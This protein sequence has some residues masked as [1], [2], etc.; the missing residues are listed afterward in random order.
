V[1]RSG[2]ELIVF[3]RESGLEEHRGAPSGA[4]DAVDAAA[5]ALTVKTLMRLPPPETVNATP[6]VEGGAE[7]RLQAGLATRIA[8]G[9]ET[10]FSGRFLGSASL[11]P[12]ARIG[13]RFGV[14]IEIGTASD[15]GQFGFRGTWTDWSVVGLA[16]WSFAT[17]PRWELEPY[18]G[19][20]VARSAVTGIVMQD[21]F[22]DTA[23]LG[24]ACAGVWVRR[25]LAMWTLGAGVGAEL[26]PGTPTYTRTGGSG[27][28]IFDVPAFG[29]EIG[30][31]ASADFG[32]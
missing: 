32:R 24:I 31:V 16:S 13:L 2:A 15:V 3:D 26:R 23:T 21:A 8:H 14:A 4:L 9:S 5:A 12:S 28:T 1:W 6:A 29:V 27:Q 20:G 17:S 25:R 22:D 7:V 11:R 18:V 19:G 10:S 30:V